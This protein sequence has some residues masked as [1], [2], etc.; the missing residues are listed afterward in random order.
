MAIWNND[1]HA[2]QLPLTVL[3][4]FLGSGKTTVLN[5]LTRQSALSRTLV[6]INEFGEIGIDSDL[7]MHCGDDIA[8]QMSNGCLCCTIKDE[9]VKTLCAAPARFSKHG[10][11]LFDRVLIETTGLADPAPIINTIMTDPRIAQHY[12][13]GGII[14]T[15]DAVNGN[16]TLD[17][18]IESVKQV[19]VA[20][21]LLITKSD[22]ADDATLRYLQNRLRLINPAAPQIF[23]MNGIIDPALLFDN[24]LYDPQTK[25]SDV[26]GWLNS[27]SYDDNRNDASHDHQHEN[28]NRHDDH[29]NAFCITF[30][31]PIQ[32]DRF[33]LWLKTLLLFRG[34]D[35]LRVKGI[36]NIAG[37]HAPVVFHAVQHILH[38]PVFLDAWP[39]DDHRSRIVFITRDVEEAELRKSLDVLAAGQ[40][41]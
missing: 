37:Q 34:P 24:R 27:E 22:L 15:I 35:F 14:A 21:K 23:A 3:T 13:L 4:G 28:V 1:G 40:D 19:A 8:M 32:Q 36:V 26:Q 9:L 7:V 30:D 20:D 2:Q 12:Y 16:E 5:H 39:N 33:Q 29:I 38:P 31:A 25:I 6:L 10:K 18:Q 41:V 17:R 11:P